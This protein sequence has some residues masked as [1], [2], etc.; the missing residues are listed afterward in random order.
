LR[1]CQF[2]KRTQVHG[3]RYFLRII[4][5]NYIVYIFFIFSKCSLFTRLNI[6]I[7]SWFVVRSGQ[8]AN[9]VPKYK[10]CLVSIYSPENHSRCSILE[11]HIV[12][13]YVIYSTYS[14]ACRTLLSQLCCA[15]AKI[16]VTVF[17]ASFVHNLVA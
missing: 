13:F 11:Y 1:D 6:C 8:M 7:L 3:V 15:G 10:L 5:G 9:S 14:I 16:L 17:C 4:D 2:L 12:T